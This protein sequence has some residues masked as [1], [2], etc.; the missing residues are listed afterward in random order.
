MK[1]S[2]YFYKEHEVKRANLFEIPAGSQ[3]LIV[4]AK[5]YVAMYEDL[6]MNDTVNMIRTFNY[7]FEFQ[8]PK[9]AN[10]YQVMCQSSS[11][12]VP[13]LYFCNS[14]SYVKLHN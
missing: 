7:G 9:Y 1:L 3:N 5:Y 11:R 2:E 10:T 8:S 4:I 14:S 13:I 12:N 6:G